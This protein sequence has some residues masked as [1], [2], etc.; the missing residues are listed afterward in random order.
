MIN[1]LISAGYLATG[2]LYSQYTLKAIYQAAKVANVEFTQVIL[3]E[4]A[5]GQWEAFININ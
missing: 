3:H 2:L 5:P 1:P 4:V